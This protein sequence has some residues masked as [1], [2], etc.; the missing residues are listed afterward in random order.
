MKFITIIFFSLILAG[1]GVAERVEPSSSVYLA[2]RYPRPERIEVRIVKPYTYGYGFSDRGELVLKLPSTK[3]SHS[4]FLWWRWD[5]LDQAQEKRVEIWL[6]D[7]L[8]GT[9]TTEQI[10]NFPIDQRGY[11]FLEL[12]PRNRLR[13]RY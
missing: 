6:E 1:C 13:S 8:L 9:L 7:K 4:Y 10:L 5:E 11:R 12:I 2:T 3:A